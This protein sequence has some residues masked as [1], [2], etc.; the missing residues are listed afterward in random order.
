MVS[1]I[2]NIFLQVG[3]TRDGSNPYCAIAKKYGY[4]TVL[5]ETNELIN[6][7]SKNF[8]ID[9]DRVIRISNPE[10][11]NAVIDA[12]RKHGYSD[13]P[14]VILA[15]FEA[16]N[17]S[18]FILKNKINNVNRQGFVPLDKYQQ[19]KK[20][21]ASDINQP[22]FYFF[23]SL[24]ALSES[25]ALN[26]YPFIIKPIDGGG[27]LGV[28]LVRTH[29]EMESVIAEL[30]NTKNYGGR[31]FSGFL[32]EEYI[33]GV[34]FSIQGIVEH[35][36]VNV[37]TCCQKIITKS[38]VGNICSFNELGHVAFTGGD[39]YGSFEDFSQRCCDEFSYS[40]GAFHIDL[41]IKNNKLYFVEMGFRISGM[42][43]TN[44]VK[45]ITGYDWAE[46]TFLLELNSENNEP[47][48]TGGSCF[49]SGRLRLQTKAQVSSAS[50][51]CM[52]SGK[53]NLIMSSFVKNEEDKRDITL[54]SDLNRHTNTVATLTLDG[55]NQ[56]EIIKVFKSIL[57]LD[58][59]PS[60]SGVNHV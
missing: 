57:A 4:I 27:G 5:V 53:G 59:S 19:R 21:A 56:E 6:L 52:A 7:Q 13:N 32:V 51:W 45:I 8:A 43:I 54:K 48:L 26:S 10:E 60:L 33:D 16:Y 29:H 31:E 34:E 17:T 50:Q 9:F 30:S 49:T 15:G 20:I 39:N 24:K 3:S 40:I 55:E 2:K 23:N 18:A 22:W 41:I 25:T 12:Y 37:L 28:Y 46:Q 42:G 14:K 38:I 36:T 11:P 35:G 58:S 47:T 1:T 44:L